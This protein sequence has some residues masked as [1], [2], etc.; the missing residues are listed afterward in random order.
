MGKITGLKA[1]KGLIGILLIGAFF[2]GCGTSDNGVSGQAS[3][4]AA[5]PKMQLVIGGSGT[6]IPITRKLAEGFMRENTDVSITITESL[7]SSGGVKTANKGLIDIGMV[8]RHL[9]PEEKTLGLQYLPYCKVL[10]AFAVHSGVNITGLTESQLLQIYSGQIKNW[11]QLGA[12]DAQI[13]VLSREQNDSSL[14][15]WRNLIK[16][17]NDLKP[18]LDINIMNTDQAMNEAISSIENSIGFTDSGSIKIENLNA[19]LVSLN[20]IAPSNEMVKAG[21]YTYVK[22]LAFV[23]KGKPNQTAQRFINYVKSVKGFGILSDYGY[24]PVKS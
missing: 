10:I 14:E 7:G 3:E 6:N 1:I 16:G 23:V 19:R 11:K 9:S 20:G 21:K 24:L 12:N 2:L 15:I 18:T 4:Q 17:F 8:S 22:E 5:F 13:V